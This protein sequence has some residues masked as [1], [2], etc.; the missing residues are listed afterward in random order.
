MIR[1]MNIIMTVAS[2]IIHC[3]C[4]VIGQKKFFSPFSDFGEASWVICI[5]KNARQY[6][7]LELNV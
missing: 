7:V 6:D 5:D 1:G 2:N 3:M 4:R